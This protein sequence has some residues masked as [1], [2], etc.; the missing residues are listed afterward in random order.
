MGRRTI[1]V[2]YD[3]LDGTELEEEETRSIDFTYNGVDYQIDLSEKNA[4]KLDDAIA[5]FVAHATRV[6]GRQRRGTGGS[7]AVRTDKEQL[8]AM[9][10]WG[11]QNGY[12]V[13]DRGRV[14]QE[15]QEAYNAAAH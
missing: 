15:I 8:Q 2:V 12:K 4:K 1:E 5:P 3:D 7:T 10:E 9:R 11:R 6:G 13:S 14:S